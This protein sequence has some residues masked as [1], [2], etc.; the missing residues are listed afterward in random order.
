M[1]FDKKEAVRYL[2]YKGVEPD[3][4]MS[5]L[6]DRCGE[7]LLS[8]IT[9]RNTWVECSLSFLKN[10]TNRTFHEK[11]LVRN[12]EQTEHG[13]SA[14]VDESTLE[15]RTS[16]SAVTDILQIEDMVIQSR[17]LYRNLKGCEKVVLFAAT[18]GLEADRLI[19]RKTAVRMSEAVIY[20]AAAAA[21]IETYCDEINEEIRL[22]YEKEGFFLRPRF[23]PGYGDVALSHQKDFCRLLI[24]SKKIGLTVTEG[25][26]MVP[27]KSVT[28]VIGLSKQNSDCHKKG[29][30]ECDKK[31]CEFRR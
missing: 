25:D 11:G 6:I 7:E 14:G 18:L 24:V 29:C 8:V 31:N 5:A 17:N 22:H 3:A 26:L 15:G 30:E 21:I 19:A 13:I 10:E 1:N 20:Q 28:A 2:G 4:D 12:E 16:G 23:S 27:I 9:P